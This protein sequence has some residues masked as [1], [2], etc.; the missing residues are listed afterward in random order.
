MDLHRVTPT[1]EWTRN[2]SPGGRFLGTCSEDFR[3]EA[4]GMWDEHDLVVVAKFPR[5][6]N[7]EKRQS[8]FKVVIRWEDMEKLIAK[9]CE[10]DRPEAVAIREALKLAAAAKTLG[11]KQPEDSPPQSN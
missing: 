3:V 6:G 11:W 5:F 4:S 1:L 10:A 8:D 9:F 7:G 2:Y